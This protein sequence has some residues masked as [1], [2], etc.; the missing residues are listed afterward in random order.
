MSTHLAQTLYTARAT[1]EGGRDGHTATDDG[2]LDVQLA[3]PPELGGQGGDG[4][5][6]EQLFAVG[7]ASCF[8]SAL[9]ITARRLKLDTTGSTVTAEIGIGP[10]TEGVGFGLSA[11]LTIRLPEISDRA[12]AERLVAATHEVC[13]Y[14]NA[15]KDT[16][17][18]TL[19]IA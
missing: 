6:P 9:F 13:P 19:T 18:V 3:T 16:I 14:S 2:R 8:Q 5:N 17:D 15:V 4:T 1:A 11:A 7:Y 10:R 12:D